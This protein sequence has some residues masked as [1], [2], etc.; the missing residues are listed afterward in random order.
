[1]GRCYSTVLGTSYTYKFLPS[2][3]GETAWLF[4]TG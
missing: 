1:M 3:P 4:A 2:L